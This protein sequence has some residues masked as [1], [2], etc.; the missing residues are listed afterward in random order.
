MLDYFKKYADEL[1]VFAI[2]GD[3]IYVI[4]SVLF[5]SLFLKNSVLSNIIISSFSIISDFPSFSN[6]NNIT[7]TTF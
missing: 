6:Y 5:S 3:M 2:F 1:G 7:F 4:L